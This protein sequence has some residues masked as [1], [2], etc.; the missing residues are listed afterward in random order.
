MRLLRRV[1]LSGALSG[2]GL[3]VACGGDSGSTP[4]SD[5]GEVLADGA[6]VTADGAV[7][8][9]PDATVP[10]EA[11]PGGSGCSGRAAD[12]A[13]ATEV[14]GYLA[15][16]TNAPRDPA[17]KEEIVE[18][19]LRTC[20]AFGPT[21]NPAFERKHCWA[22]LLASMSK[23]SGFDPKVLVRDGY[24]TRAIGNQRANDPVVGLLQ[25]RFSSTVHEMVAL[26]NAERL[27]CVG[28]PI[29]PAISA[30]AAEGG[31]T[32]YWAVTGPSENL[33]LMQNVACNVG[34][35]AWFYYVNATGN[36]KASAVTYPDAYCKGQ[37]TGGNLVTGLLSHLKGSEAGRGFIANQGALDALRTTDAG[38]HAYVTEIKGLFE[39]MAGPSAGESPFFVRL[40]PD[41]TM[42][43]Q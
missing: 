39:R 36:G 29:P 12:P 14:E 41:T 16:L 43:C 11:G 19:V 22:H 13:A 30:H 15:K 6:V 37:G 35:G 27:A 18:A 25:I 26:G 10:F 8:P 24:G 38:G 20:A 32:P 7:V 17:L 1:A 31:S 5:A 34:M 40:S 2:L 28:C 3:A 4:A 33:A 23:E 9:G 42:Y 21:S